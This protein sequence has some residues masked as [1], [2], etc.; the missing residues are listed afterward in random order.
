MCLQKLTELKI[1]GSKNFHQ[2]KTKIMDIDEM[3]NIWKEDMNALES[4]IQINEKK[5]KELEFNRATTTFDKFLKI[6]LVC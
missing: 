1:S 6:S 2:L 5:I 4:R 3:K